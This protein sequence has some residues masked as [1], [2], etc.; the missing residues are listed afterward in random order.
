MTGA[1]DDTEE[2]TVPAGPDPAVLRRDPA[3]H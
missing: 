3:A 2:I 1:G